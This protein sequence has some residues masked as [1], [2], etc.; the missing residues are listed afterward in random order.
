[1]KDVAL[2]IQ[3]AA[4]RGYKLTG[5]W[6]YRNTAANASVNGSPTSKHLDRKAIDLNLFD[7]Q[8]FLQDTADHAELG[9]FWES[10][11]PVNRWG[12]RFNDGNHYERMD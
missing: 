2:L 7:G 12:G 5:N 3:F 6:L 4:N 8:V 11:R 1:M 10:L 9:A